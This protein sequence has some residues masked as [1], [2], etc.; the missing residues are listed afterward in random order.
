[1]FYFRP[2]DGQFVLVERRKALAVAIAPGPTIEAFSYD[3]KITMSRPQPDGK[4]LENKVLLEKVSP[5]P[6]LAVSA[7]R[8][9][10]AGGD[11]NG[12]VNIWNAATQRLEI[13]LN[14]RSAVQSLAFSPDNN[15]LAIGLAKPSGESADTAWLLDIGANTARRSF[16]SNSVLAL[17]WSR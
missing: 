8:H 15:T 13:Q 3:D 11:S 16:A 12:V 9:F 10:L 7:D 2:R 4:M 5:Q 1:V 17:A 6:I 14:E